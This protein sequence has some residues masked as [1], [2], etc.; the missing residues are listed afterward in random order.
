VGTGASPDVRAAFCAPAGRA[1]TAAAR[2]ASSLTAGPTGPAAAREDLP[3]KPRPSPAIAALSSAGN[4]SFSTAF[5]PTPNG[6][7]GTRTLDIVHQPPAEDGVYG[8]G[9]F[10]GSLSV[11]QTML[12]TVSTL[13][14]AVIRAGREPDANGKRMMMAA[15]ATARKTMAADLAASA[16]TQDI[17]LPAVPDVVRLTHIQN[18]EINAILFR[19][20]EAQKALS[21]MPTVPSM[22]DYRQAYDAVAL[23]QPTASQSDDAYM[24]QVRKTAAEQLPTL[25]PRNDAL[26]YAD[27]DVAYPASIHPDAD[28]Y[29]LAAEVNAF[30]HQKLTYLN[31]QSLTTTAARFIDAASGSTQGV[32]GLYFNA[33]QDTVDLHTAPKGQEP[34]LK[35][36]QNEAMYS[37]AVYDQAKARV[38]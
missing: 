9:H 6:L 1:P 34:P 29:P 8:P 3:G 22:A 12:G 35:V 38:G 23:P 19:H 10:R 11:E 18:H 28:R 33:Y 27:L 37:D 30:L 20:Y 16:L 15:H 4:F 31:G 26:D 24:E 36:Y 13:K 5:A 32:A 21:A 17:A 25:A 2:A 7:R 14:V